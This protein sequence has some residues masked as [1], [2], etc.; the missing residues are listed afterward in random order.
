MSHS[1]HIHYDDDN[2]FKATIW[3]TI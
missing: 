1:I 3:S 2:Q